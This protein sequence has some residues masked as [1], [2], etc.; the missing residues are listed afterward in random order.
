MDVHCFLLTDIFLV[1]KQTAKKAHGN[2][3]VSWSWA[4]V[5]C[6]CEAQAQAQGLITIAW[7][8]RLSLHNNVYYDV[9]TYQEIPSLQWQ[10]FQMTKGFIVCCWTISHRFLLLPFFFLFYEHKNLTQKLS[11]I[12]NQENVLLILSTES[13]S[14]G[15]F[16]L[17]IFLISLLTHTSLEPCPSFVIL[18]HRKS[19]QDIKINFSRSL[20]S[21]THACQVIRQPYLTDRLIVKLREKE[22]TL[23]CVY[24]NE[25]NMAVGAFNLQCNEAKNWY[26]GINKAR[27]IY[28]KLKQDSD[29]QLSRHH[30]FVNHNNNNTSDNLSIRKSPLG[31]SIGELSWKFRFHVDIFVCYWLSIPNHHHHPWFGLGRVF[32]RRS[33]SASVTVVCSTKL[34]TQ[35]IVSYFCF[36]PHMHAVSSLNNSNSGSVEFNESKTVSV[37]FEK[38]NSI[39]SDEGSYS[40][41]QKAPTY[42]IVGGAVVGGGSIR[43]LRQTSNSLTV[44]TY[45]THLNQS[46]PNLASGPFCFNPNNTL[47]VPHPQKSHS[48]HSSHSG[49]LLSPSQRGISYPPPSPNRWVCGKRIM[50]ANIHW[51]ISHFLLLSTERH[52]VAASPSPRR[53]TTRIHRWWSRAMSPRWISRISRARRQRCQQHSCAAQCPARPATFTMSSSIRTNHRKC[54]WTPSQSSSTT[55]ARREIWWNFFI[56][57][58]PAGEKRHDERESDR[59]ASKRMRKHLFFINQKGEKS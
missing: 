8:W 36:L 12:S 9:S 28:M 56:D 38:T 48:A 44:Q 20:F 15:Y 45:S 19:E 17:W 21:P 18:K 10:Q 29:N 33:F 22:N 30:S 43:K 58:R 42:T 52:F 13:W 34:I 39:S 16:W 49:N 40:M 6:G 14:S 53:S 26:D 51:I 35:L 54:S 37:D 41:H 27:H 47:L 7:R 50:C 59:V 25:F 32:W 24:L 31:S 3:K 55:R 23:Q 46:M 1:C 2:L 11:Q 5:L 57:T 4:C